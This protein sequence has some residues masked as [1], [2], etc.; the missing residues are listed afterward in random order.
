MEND[1]TDSGT[2]RA[3]TYLLDRPVTKSMADPRVA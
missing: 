2:I 1:K 3:A